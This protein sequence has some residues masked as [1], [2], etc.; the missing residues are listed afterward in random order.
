MNVPQRV[1]LCEVGPR[2]GLQNEAT[3]VAT[4][5][6]VRYIG[7][8]AQAGFGDIEVTSFVSPKAVPQL[9]DAEDV[10]TRLP[11]VAGCRYIVLVPNDRGLNR[12]LAAGA[13]AIAVFTAA[14]DTFTQRNI[15]MTIE[16]SLAA[17]ASVVKRAKADDVWVRASIS[18]SFG[19][20][21]RAASHPRRSC[22]SPNVC[23]H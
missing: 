2:D 21:S 8:L 1:H 11:P 23:W 15:G 13:R 7:M 14:S 5:D 4:S 22:A 6:K 18:T 17:F 3:N 20:P 12:A 16:E 9:A 19:C 10:F